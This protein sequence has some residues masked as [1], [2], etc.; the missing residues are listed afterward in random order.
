MKKQLFAIPDRCTGC[1]RCA[2]ICSASHEGVFSPYL[3]RIQIN[4]FA[5][6][7]YSVQSICFQCSKASCLEVCPES[8][9]YK[10]DGVVLV[11]R[12]KCSGCGECVSACPYG[13]IEID[14]TGGVR[15]CDL[16]GG[17]PLCVEECFTKA[18]VYCEPTADLAKLKGAQLRLRS[19]QGSPGEKRFRL[20]KALMDK[21]RSTEE[22]DTAQKN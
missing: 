8:A 14:N 9:L 19:Q 20:G 12:D 13:M 4:N 10:D 18:L 6:R 15:K 5:S 3:S 21:A 1:N 22:A 17:A 7:G 16:C 11:Q 2:Y